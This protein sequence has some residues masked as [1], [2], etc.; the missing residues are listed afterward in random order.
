[1]NKEFLHAS[2][3]SRA[4]PNT[5]NA[6]ETYLDDVDDLEL[7][8]CPL[9]LDWPSRILLMPSMRMLSQKWSLQWK[10]CA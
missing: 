6:I 10:Y 8:L 3:A 4:L 9:C 2:Y 1:M 5:I 7:D